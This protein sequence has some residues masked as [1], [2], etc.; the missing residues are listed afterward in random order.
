MLKFSNTLASTGKFCTVEF[1]K[2]DGTIRK[3]NG[4][5]NVQKYLKGGAERN[6]KTKSQYLLIWTR[7]G[8]RRFDAVQNI[9]RDR[10]ISIRAHGIK[11]HMNN[12]SQ[13]S[14]TV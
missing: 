7:N 14:Q 3:I 11:M 13:Y 8:S 4:R 9:A 5:S 2:S 6:E 1:I 12:A 10:I